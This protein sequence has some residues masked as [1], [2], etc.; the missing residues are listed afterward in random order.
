M[1]FNESVRKIYKEYYEALG[2]TEK[3]EFQPI[4]QSKLERLRL[5]KPN[6]SNE[7]DREEES[8]TWYTVEYTGSQRYI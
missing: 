2:P 1:S 7:S 4:L 6:E 8:T 5:S 3:R